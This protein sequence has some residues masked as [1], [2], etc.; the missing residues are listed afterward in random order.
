MTLRRV[1]SRLRFGG[2]RT[3]V[4]ILSPIVLLAI[5]ELAGRARIIDVRFFPI[6]TTVFAETV[7]DIRNGFLWEQVSVSLLRIGVGYTIGALLGA[8]LGLL[9]GL[10]PIVRAAFAPLVNATYP[11]PKSALLPLFLLVFG[12]GEQSKWAIIAVATFYLVLINAMAGVLTIEKIF[13]DVGVNYGASSLLKLRDI[14]LPGALPVIFAGLKLGMGVSLIVLVYAESVGATTGIG[15]MIWNAWQVFD[16]PEMYAGIL[17]TAVIGFLLAAL[18]DAVEW[19][20]V[21]W[22]R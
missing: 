15:Y 8:A 18:L 21:P 9:M 12:L 2:W 17:T 13:L 11:I 10:I 1:L 6:P 16:V 7:K 19:V 20:V 4:S 14:A 3:L 22:R 5:W